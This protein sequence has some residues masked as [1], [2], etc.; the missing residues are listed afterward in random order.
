MAK[1]VFPDLS[2]AYA[3]EVTSSTVEHT[4]TWIIP[5]SENSTPL[6]ITSFKLNGRFSSLFSVH[7][8]GNSRL[9]ENRL[10][11]WFSPSTY[12]I[13][14][15]I[16]NSGIQNPMV[17]TWLI[18]SMDEAIAD[19]YPMYPTTKAI[20]DA[21]VLAYSDTEDSSKLFPLNESSTDFSGT[22]LFHSIL[23]LS[24][25]T[26]KTTFRSDTRN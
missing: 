11:G 7:S 17:M 25:T 4:L 21:I 8:N 20:W 18:N 24:D 14:S 22:W 12:E 9:R 10:H 16:C 1:V 23:Y 2:R 5:S 13:W 15:R 6:T 3:A 26:T 19:I